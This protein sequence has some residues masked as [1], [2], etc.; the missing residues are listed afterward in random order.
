MRLLDLLFPERRNSAGVAKDRLKIVL[1]HERASRNAPDF[2]PALQKE[3]LEVVGRYVEIRDDMLRINV[4]KSGDT[5][6][7]EINVEIDRALLRPVENAPVFSPADPRPV[8]AAVFTCG[9]AGARIPQRECRSRGG[10][11]EKVDAADLKSAPLPRVRVRVPPSA[12][13]FS[14]A[15]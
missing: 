2:L 8:R 4:G 14:K 13:T 12:P 5:S 9:R 7:L 1:A 3:L 11:G 6:M 15:W 10:R